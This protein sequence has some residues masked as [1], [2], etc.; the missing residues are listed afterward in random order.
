MLML[1]T[2]VAG[3]HNQLGATIGGITTAPVPQSLHGMQMIY[4]LLVLLVTCSGGKQI[5][6]VISV[7]N[8]KLTIPVVAAIVTD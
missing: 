1:L 3:V 5:L 4:G 8:K 2:M 7:L 6:G